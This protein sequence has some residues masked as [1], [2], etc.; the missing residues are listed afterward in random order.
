MDGVSMQFSGEI[1]DMSLEEA[2]V[3][4]LSATSA[5]GTTTIT[6]NTVTFATSSSSS[7]RFASTQKSNEQAS[8]EE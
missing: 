6:A 5:S 4:S 3:L 1:S 2:L 8:E 7:I